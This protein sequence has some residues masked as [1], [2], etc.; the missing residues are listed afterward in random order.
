LAL[1]SLKKACSKKKTTNGSLLS[2]L[3]L[4]VNHFMPDMPDDSRSEPR[5][6]VNID[7]RVVLLGNPDLRVQG[8]MVDLSHSGAR[9][10]ISSPISMGQWIKAE[11]GKHFLI[12]KPRH[13]KHTSIGYL[14]GLR[15]HACS[16]WNDEAI[17][18]V[19]KSVTE[20]F[21]EPPPLNGFSRRHVVCRKGTPAC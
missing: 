12:G 16:W 21:T 13:I 18:A 8:R 6:H 9:L 14:V 1:Q 5:L 19:S 3:R 11:W 17:A 2:V 20:S 10:L 15:L 7:V 4:W